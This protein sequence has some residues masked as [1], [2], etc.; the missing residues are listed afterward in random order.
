[1]KKFII[2]DGQGLLYRTFYALPR[3]TTSY[4]QIIN[5]VYGFTIILLKLIEEE[6]PDYIVVAFDTSKPTFRHKEF[7]DYKIHRKRMP[8]NGKKGRKKKL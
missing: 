5:A 7:E 2:I 8:D 3:L 1:M 4:G 6:K